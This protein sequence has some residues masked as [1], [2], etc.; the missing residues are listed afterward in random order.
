MYPP[1]KKTGVFIRTKACARTRS[2]NATAHVHGTHSAQN[3]ESRVSAKSCT[4]RSRTTCGRVQTG[5]EA[6]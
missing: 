3:A 6:L 2:K 1:K 5:S 4:H